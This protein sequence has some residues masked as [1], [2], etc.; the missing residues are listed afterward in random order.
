V[1]VVD[2]FVLAWLDDVRLGYDLVGL[3]AGAS[4][5]E[6]SFNVAVVDGEFL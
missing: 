4:V 1:V 6:L 3:F 5:F 2:V